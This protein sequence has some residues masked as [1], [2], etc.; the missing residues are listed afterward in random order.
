MIVWLASFPRSGNT[1]LRTILKQTLGVGS[2]SDELVHPIVGLTETAKDGFGHLVMKEPWEA[3]Y[4]RAKE[5][6]KTYFV[7]THLPPRDDQPVIYVVRDGRRSLVSYH[8]YH[9]RFLGEQ[10][11]SLLALVLGMDYY[12][13]WSE[14][15]RN[16]ISDKRKTL[17]LRYEDLVNASSQLVR[18]IAE[19]VDYDGPL[20]EWSNPFDQLH[21]ENPEFFRVGEIKWKETAGW[22]ELTNSVFFLLHGVLMNELAYAGREEIEQARADL[23]PELIEMTEIV[24]Q[25]QHNNIS[26]GKICQ[27][28]LSVIHVLDAEVRRLNALSG[29]PELLKKKDI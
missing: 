2:Y 9:K 28:R 19:F 23:S 5:S 15:Y 1:L 27:E 21:M 22:S 17:L 6:E 29:Q 25:A 20:S 8:E 14:H 24:Q 16:W 7:K 3:F 18:S 11:L 4:E 13:G 26:L 12:G 10:S